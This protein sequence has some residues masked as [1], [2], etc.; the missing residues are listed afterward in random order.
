MMETKRL[1]ACSSGLASFKKLHFSMFYILRSYRRLFFYWQII[2]YW[3]NIQRW[4]DHSTLQCKVHHSI[5]IYWFLLIIKNM[6]M[7]VMS[8]H[9]WKWIVFLFKVDQTEINPNVVK[10]LLQS[11]I[12][13][14]TSS[15]SICIFSRDIYWLYCRLELQKK[16]LELN[17]QH[18]SLLKKSNTGKL[19]F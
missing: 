5:I 4:H 18:K 10:L 12:L 13:S 16:K 8:R 9:K 2:F 15:I 3:K 7:E 14:S 6:L 11:C 17:S 1:S 19:K